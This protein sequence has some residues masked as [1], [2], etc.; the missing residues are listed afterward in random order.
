MERWWGRDGQTGGTYGE[1]VLVVACAVVDGRWWLD[2]CER[3]VDL[4][5][6]CGE[7]WLGKGVG[8]VGEMAVQWWWWWWWYGHFGVELW[9]W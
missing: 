4:V 6:G 3:I 2:G 1:V 7:R 8:Q 9:W 5:D